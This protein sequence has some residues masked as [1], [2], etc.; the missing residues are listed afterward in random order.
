MRR[1]AILWEAKG[2]IGTP[3]S[4]H[5]CLKG[6]GVDCVGFINGVGMETE[7]IDFTAAR[8]APFKGYHRIPKPKQLVRYCNTFLKPAGIAP[9]E[10]AP[11]G[12]VGLIAWRKDLT[13]HFAIRSTLRDGR[14][15]LIHADGNRGSVV[16]H[17][18]VDDWHRLIHSWW[19]FPG[20]E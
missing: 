15:S 4:H 6:V 5:Q 16:E 1:E 13:L 11:I 2:W 8:W 12:S 9:S 7:T 3:F 20:A 14:A 17:A 18:L 10:V 19:D